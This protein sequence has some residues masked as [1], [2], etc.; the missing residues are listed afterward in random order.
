MA[1]AIAMVVVLLVFPVLFL[2]SMVGVA[3]LLGEALRRS[4]EKAFEGSELVD[5]NR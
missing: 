5:L 4:R 2:M 1:G 3:A